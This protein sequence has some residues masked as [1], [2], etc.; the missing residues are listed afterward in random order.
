MVEIDAAKVAA[1]QKRVEA[2]ELLHAAG[3]ESSGST[4]GIQMT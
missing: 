2:L 4:V 3:Q 1:L